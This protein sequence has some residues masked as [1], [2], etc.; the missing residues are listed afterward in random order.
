MGHITCTVD[1]TLLKNNKTEKTS[2]T[3]IKPLWISG[4]KTGVKKVDT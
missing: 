4:R 1:N 2:I 3:I